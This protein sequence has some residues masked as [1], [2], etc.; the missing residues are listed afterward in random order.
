MYEGESCSGCFP[1]RVVE[2]NKG[3]RLR[4]TLPFYDEREKKEKLTRDEWLFYGPGTYYPQI[5]AEVV[6]V[7]DIVFIGPEEGL[8]FTQEELVL[9]VTAL[10]VT[11]DVDHVDYSGTQRKAGELWLVT[12]K[13][14]YLPSANETVVRTVAALRLSDTVAHHFEAIADCI[15]CFCLFFLSDES[16]LSL[17]RRQ[18]MF[19]FSLIHGQRMLL[20]IHGKQ[21]NSG[22]LRR[23]IPE[24]IFRAY[25]KTMSDLYLCKF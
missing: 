10:L 9:T 18:I 14:G 11:A 25:R 22:W 15:V 1:L 21:E 20:E 13:G 8:S 23:K 6:S 12:E 3:L 7:Q 4:A 17:V 19:Y 16:F 2:E 24:L 5:E